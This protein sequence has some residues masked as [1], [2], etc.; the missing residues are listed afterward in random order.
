[1]K[2]LAVT[3]HGYDLS[4]P[5]LSPPQRPPTTRLDTLGK[6]RAGAGKREKLQRAGNAGKGKERKEALPDFV[7]FS[8]RICGSVVM[9]NPPDDLDD[10]ECSFKDLSIEG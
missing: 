9:A 7:R 3:T 4:I 1:M 8:G 10:F 5:L 6:K 2:S